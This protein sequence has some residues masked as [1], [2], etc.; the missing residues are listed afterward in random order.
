MKLRTTEILLTKAKYLRKSFIGDG[1]GLALQKP[2]KGLCLT[3]DIE[4]GIE[5]SNDFFIPIIVKSHDRGQSFG[6][7]NVNSFIDHQNV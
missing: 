2:M 6:M 1:E 7:T 5:L 3:P 4:I